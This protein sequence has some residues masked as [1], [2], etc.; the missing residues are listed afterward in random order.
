MVS[1]PVTLAEAMELLHYVC[2]VGHLGTGS[3]L[4]E[5]VGNG[6]LDTMH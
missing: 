6:L 1:L 5:R 2:S 4:L 3:V